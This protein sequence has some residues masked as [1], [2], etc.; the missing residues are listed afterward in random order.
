MN[1]LVPVLDDIDAKTAVDL[2]RLPDE[3]EVETEE[4]ESGN[5]A[6]PLAGA[7][8]KDGD[9]MFVLVDLGDDTG[10]DILVLELRL[11][12]VL[13]LGLVTTLLDNP[14]KV[15]VLPVLTVL[16]LTVKIDRELALVLGP[17]DV[18]VV[19]P[20]CTDAELEPSPVLLVGLW[21]VALLE[22]L[23]AGFALELE[24]E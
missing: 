6:L 15:G 23:V 22:R 17:G 5:E 2:V 18:V 19:E 1:A 9:P 21:F 4:L 20:M 8:E 16:Q 7:T 10:C 11:E 14:A 13:V 12:K 24:P 3:N